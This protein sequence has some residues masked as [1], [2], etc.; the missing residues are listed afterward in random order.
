[1]ESNHDYS[2]DVQF[3]R[4]SFDEK[5]ARFDEM[6]TKLRPCDEFDEKFKELVRER[7]SIVAWLMKRKNHCLRFGKFKGIKSWKREIKREEKEL[8]SMLETILQCREIEQTR[9]E[10]F[11]KL[12]F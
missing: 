1:M 2:H 6:L 9:R 8:R 5:A 3:Q 12:A 4:Q 10:A 11:G 7:E